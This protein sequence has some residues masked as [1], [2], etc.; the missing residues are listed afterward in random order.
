MSRKETVDADIDYMRMIMKDWVPRRREQ[1]VFSILQ[2]KSVLTEFAFLLKRATVPILIPCCTK[3]SVF[4][5]TGS[6]L[7]LLSGSKPF[8]TLK[9]HPRNKMSRTWKA[10]VGNT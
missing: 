10:D 5:C 6:G 8:M 1:S 2:M 3:A 7:W 4:G 9:C